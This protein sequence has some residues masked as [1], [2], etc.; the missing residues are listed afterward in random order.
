MLFANLVNRCSLSTPLYTRLLEGVYR[1]LASVTL[2][3]G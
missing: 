2:E 3:I 1:L